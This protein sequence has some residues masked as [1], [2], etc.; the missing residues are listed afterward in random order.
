M[1]SLTKARNAAIKTEID[2]LHMAIMNY[3]NEYGSF[4]PCFD[5]SG[6]PASPAISPAR[7]HLERLFPRCTNPNVQFTAA[8]LTGQQ[9]WPT[10][11]PANSIVVWLNGYTTDPLSP[12][13]P[14][15]DRK[16]LYDF[17][18]TRITTALTY[19]PSGKSQSP[20]IFIK[21]GVSP[22]G[23][24]G[25]IATSGPSAG[26]TNAS[27]GTYKPV[28]R[29]TS[30]GTSFFNPESFQI[31]CAGRDEIWDEDSNM[32]GVLEP[33]EDIDGDG[34]WDKSDDDLSN[35]WPG[36]RREYLDSLKN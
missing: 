14:D 17:D 22:T 27:Y 26:V 31:L 15:A 24:Y 9:A 6:Y 32:N 34:V 16:R 12:L 11:D 28:V 29:I 8:G 2:M 19:H 20:Y 13:R 33:A 18:R 4:P 25:V 36:T 30:S 35:F 7:S 23:G 21:S 3:K 10:I 5:N 1:Q